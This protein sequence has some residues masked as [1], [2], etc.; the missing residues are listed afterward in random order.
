MSSD[1]SGAQQQGPQTG[2]KTPGL[3]AAHHK[4]GG[5]SSGHSWEL[6]QDEP[7]GR[8]WVCPCGETREK[9]YG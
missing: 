1:D 5:S 7:L 3:G 2:A 6:A 4:D 8:M 9:R